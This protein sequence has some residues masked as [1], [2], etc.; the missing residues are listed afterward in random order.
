MKTKIKQA[1]IDTFNNPNNEQLKHLAQAFRIAG[2]AGFLSVV[3]K[4]DNS[5][6]DVIGLVIGWATFEACAIITLR[7]LTE[8]EK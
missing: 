5:A 7:F 2:V 8:G 6:L 3:T 1:I 4:G